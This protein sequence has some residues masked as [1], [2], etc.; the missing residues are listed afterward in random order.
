VLS[1]G[2][3][4]DDE[5]IKAINMYLS[6][7]LIRTST[8]IPALS[9]KSTLVS[10]SNVYEQHPIYTPNFNPVFHNTNNP[11]TPVNINSSDEFV[12]LKNTVNILITRLNDMDAKLS[13]TSKIIQK[14]KSS[15][16]ENN[17]SISHD[18]NEVCFQ[19]TS[20]STLFKD[21]FN[22]S[23]VDY[24]TVI[25]NPNYEHLPYDLRNQIINCVRDNPHF[26]FEMTQFISTYDVVFK[27]LTVSYFKNNSFVNALSIMNPS[28]CD[29]LRLRYQRL[30]D[31]QTY[32]MLTKTKLYDLPLCD[33]Q[34]LFDNL[35]PHAFTID[36]I[37]Q[38]EQYPMLSN[39]QRFKNAFSQIFDSCWQDKLVSFETI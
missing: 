7:S 11:N 13:Q 36:K 8:S 16:I 27:E 10:E 32:T 28:L 15:K 19:T 26:V 25:E 18:E 4:F 31:M 30:S 39:Q 12:S 2:K 29:Y 37:A 5:L 24:L 20:L 17:S 22:L 3:N 35:T 34:Q 23:V 9:Q 21:K 38:E 1:E 6:N 14:T 33:I